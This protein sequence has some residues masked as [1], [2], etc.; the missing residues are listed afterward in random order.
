M[1]AL[2]QEISS[3]VGFHHIMIR[4]QVAGDLFCTVELLISRMHCASF[5]HFYSGWLCLISFQTEVSVRPAES[6]EQTRISQGFQCAC[7]FLAMLVS[8][9]SPLTAIAC[10]TL[11]TSG[12]G[13]S[14]REYEETV[15]TPHK[16]SAAP[17]APT[18]QRLVIC[19]DDTTP[20]GAPARVAPSRSSRMPR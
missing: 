11:G 2:A 1:R 19:A 9:A 4:R 12:Q 8:S 18:Q 20:G 3:L 17:A 13:T 7:D 14:P 16:Q 10:C 15:D 5:S 6:R